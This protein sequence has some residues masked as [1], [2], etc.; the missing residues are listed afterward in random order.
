MNAYEAYKIFDKDGDEKD[1][2]DM[3]ELALESQI[4]LFGEQHNSPVAHYLQ[5]K[6][7]KSIHQKDSIITIGA[8]MFESDDQIVIDEFLKGKIRMKD[9]E[10]EAKVWDN[11]TTDYKMFLEYADKNKLPF[12]ATNIPRRYASLLARSGEAELIKLTDDA[13]KYICPLPFDFDPELPAYKEMSNM[14]AGHGMPF[15]AQSQAIK[16]A[17][18]AYFIHKNFNHRFYHLNGAYHSNNF[19]A[20]NWYLKKLN[21]GYKIMT[22]SVVVQDNV[23]ELLNE[24]KNLA[25]FIIVVNSDFPKSY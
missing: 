21:P 18:M 24:N 16:D 8:E 23:E 15:I 25:D 6:L 4:V 13:K 3:L 14:G 20:I 19:E 5:Y 9:L 17:T 2:E 12:I 7:L 11:F 10:K 22:I 1:S